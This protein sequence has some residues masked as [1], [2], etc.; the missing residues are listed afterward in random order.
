MKYCIYIIVA[1][2]MA[3]CKVTSTAD[4]IALQP[5]PGHFGNGTESD[6]TSVGSFT[7]RNYFKDKQ[8]IT[9]IDTA[10]V[11][12]Q[13][14]LIAM[15]RMRMA[16]SDVLF[17]K[18]LLLPQIEGVATAGVNR[19]GKYT[20][21]GAGNMGTPI[22]GDETIPALL[23]DY[24]VGLQTSWEADIWGK[25]RNKKK[26]AAL[27]YLS[28]AEAKNVVLTNLV[29]DVAAGYYELVTL[30]NTLNIIKEYL[31]LQE[32]AL[33]I[34]R[35][36]KEAAVVNRLAV[37]QFEANV[38]NSRARELQVLQQIIVTENRVNFLLGRFPQ[39]VERQ[40]EAIE[41]DFSQVVTTGLPAGLLRN[42]ADIREAE[43]NMMAAKA[44]VKSA[45]AAF[46][47]SLNIGASIGYQAFRPNLLF[48]SPQSLAYSL[49]GTLAAPLLNR[50]AIKA[51][52]N[53]ADALQV[54]TLY[55]YQKTILTA[56]AEVNNEMSGLANFEGIVK[57]KQQETAVLERSIETSLTLFKAN[58]A[59]YLE[60]L[61]AQQNALEAKIT[62]MDTKMQRLTSWV[63]IYKALGG[64]WR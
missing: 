63:N 30:D 11:N 53:T 33:E 26:A 20:M 17:S 40:K 35:Y 61:L 1:L 2:L 46:Y 25:L 64:G 16:Q 42:R 37:E 4:S 34:M 3:G 12:N 55:N 19:F 13:D 50:K 51:E 10:I 59:T 60:V 48:S 62:L 24:F 58:R 38:I 36:Q 31:V 18:S 15:Q 28:S 56:Y 49:V 21:D 39:P 7:W 47:P 23:P 41:E 57:L 22:Y 6:T 14:V 5:L 32:K 52:F 45:R 43:L 29:A 9:L 54:E 8:L 44:D 27:R